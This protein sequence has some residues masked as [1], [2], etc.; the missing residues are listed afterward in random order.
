MIPILWTVLLAQMAGAAVTF[1]NQAEMFATG[2]TD[3]GIQAT[4][5]T[6]TD[7]DYTCSAAKACSI[8]CCG[9]L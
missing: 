2:T 8:G 4:D 9:P 1:A 3:I 5:D 7:A 6:D